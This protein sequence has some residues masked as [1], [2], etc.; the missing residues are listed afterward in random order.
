MGRLYRAVVGVA[1]ALTTVGVANAEAEPLTKRLPRLTSYNVE[2]YEP[3]PQNEAL[4]REFISEVLTFV[5]LH[6]TGHMVFSTYSVPV[7]SRDTEESAADSFAAAVLTLNIDPG[8]SEPHNPLKSAA[9]FW[10]ATDALEQASPQGEYDW[11]DEHSPPEQRA[12]KAACLLYGANPQAFAYI[13]EAFSLQKAR[14]DFC[15]EDTKKNGKTWGGIISLHINPNRGSPLDAWT[16]RVAVLHHP[17]PESLPKG[18]SATQSRERQLVQ[19]LGTLDLVAKNLLALKKSAK[20]AALDDLQQKLRMPPR[21]PPMDPMHT[22]MTPLIRPS[23]DHPAEGTSLEGYNY[24]VV[25]DSCLNEQGMPA[26][27][28]WWSDA[29]RSITLCY[30]LVG[31]VEKI[32]KLLI[33]A[34]DCTRRGDCEKLG[35]RKDSTPGSPASAVASV[36]PAIVG[37]WE[38]SVP[39]GRWILEIAANGTFVF[40]SEAMDGV[41]SRSGTFSANNGHWSL[42]A[43]DGYDDEGTY[44]VL[45]SSVWTGTSKRLGPGTWRRANRQH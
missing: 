16:P 41:P 37:T 32:G 34:D 18:L 14:R 30:G 45:P 12:F 11:A 6:E 20:D 24:T 39:A 1:M 44:K 21:N 2:A 8:R 28:A 23:I 15:V 22:D 7:G 27:N 40:H 9:L 26:I 31:K 43:T 13:A 3:T 42:Q 29:R 19:S 17:V 5:M 4:L 10:D 36:D 38:A 35:R 33:A 25:G